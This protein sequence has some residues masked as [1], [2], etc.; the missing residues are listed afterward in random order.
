MRFDDFWLD[1]EGG[2]PSGD[3]PMATDGEHAAEIT[4]AKFKDLKFMV[5]PENPQGT[6]L[7]LAVNI[8]GFRPLE[9]IIPA[10]MRWL[11]ESVCRSAS[12]NV[13]VKGQDW[14]CEH[15]VGRQVRVETVFGIAKS[16]REYVR[17]DKWVAGPE[18]LPPAAAKPAP[19]RTPAAKV[20]AVGQG[21]SPDD[22]P[23]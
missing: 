6:S 13:P 5:K 17:V 20:E 8:N 9:A 23:F 21:G 22:I 11:I 12:V 1:D 14:D 10:Q 19:A 7:V 15:L 16:G 3:L 2:Q 18:P 4:D